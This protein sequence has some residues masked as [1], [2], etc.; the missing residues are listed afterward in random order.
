MSDSEAG[1]AVTSLAVDGEIAAYDVKQWDRSLPELVMET[2]IRTKYRLCGLPEVYVEWLV[3]T[4]IHPILSVPGFGEI[5]LRC[6]VWPSGL[7]ETLLG[8][9]VVHAA[10]VR[11]LGL[12]AIVLGDDLVV[13]DRVG[14]VE[15]Y[16]RAGLELIRDD[17]VE[18]LRGKPYSRGLYRDLGRVIRKN[19]FD[20]LGGMAF[21][22]AYSAWQTPYTSK[23]LVRG[24]KYSQL[25]DIYSHWDE[26]LTKRVGGQGDKQSLSLCLAAE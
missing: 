16:A 13:K 6:G 18:F 4:L 15:D 12:K 17:H 9:S 21:L 5:R 11:I 23:G 3:K 24:K 25:V 26:L 22:R 7:L 1:A 8:N 19:V 14:I 2:F 20:E 10:L